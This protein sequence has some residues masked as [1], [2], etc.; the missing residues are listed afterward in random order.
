MTPI[1]IGIIG[2]FDPIGKPHHAAINEAITHSAQ[3]LGLSAEIEWLATPSLAAAAAPAR[4][5]QCGGLFASSGSPYASKAAA[6]EAIRFARERGVPFL[7][8]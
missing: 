5:A 1:K 6:L 7:A 2:D 8:T 3:A 4:L